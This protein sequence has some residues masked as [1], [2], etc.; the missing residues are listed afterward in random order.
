MDRSGLAVPFIGF[1]FSI[2]FIIHSICNPN[3]LCLL[4]CSIVPVAAVQA[5]DLQ[6]MVRRKFRIHLQLP[7]HY[8]APGACGEAGI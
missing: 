7:Q 4:G 5:A 1:S 3:L 6:T 2:K 8:G